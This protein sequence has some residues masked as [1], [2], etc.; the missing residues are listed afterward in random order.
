LPIQLLFAALFLSSYAPLL[1]LMGG[2]VSVF[3]T[4]A[5]L[6][7]LIANERGQRAA[8]AGLL[9]FAA[10]FKFYPVIFVLPFATRRDDRFVLFAAAACGVLL[11]AI[12]GVL[13]GPGDTVRFYGALL[14]AFRHSDWVVTNPHSQF[15]PHVVLRL[16]DPA[17]P[18]GSPYLPLLRWISY[19]VALANAGLVCLVQRARMR[20]AD[21][22]SFQLLFLTVPFILK[23]SWSADF[24]FLSF[25]QAFLLWLIL[26]EE[27]TA[28]G[29]GTA[30]AGS[31]S[32]SGE[33]GRRART[34]VTCCALLVSI[35]LSSDVF[36]CLV[37]DRS[38]SFYGSSFWAD[39]VLLLASYWLLLPPALQQPRAVDGEDE[40]PA[41]KNPRVKAD[42]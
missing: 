38:Y 26:E 4:A 14:D 27:R 25:T 31:R 13:L 19:G 18:G 33:S 24:V 35:V 20:H 17:G 22:W 11:L 42:G 8:A 30:G 34:T 1:N 29:D 36:F 23:T 12:P 41:P 3:M 10:S 28:P 6:G 15:F 7:V 21:L 32:R 37:G 40:R 9:A 39:L 5:I 2:S 16:L